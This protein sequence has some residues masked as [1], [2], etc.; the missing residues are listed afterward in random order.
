MH[1]NCGGRGAV[2]AMGNP[3]AGSAA[4]TRIAA[5]SARLLSH[6]AGVGCSERRRSR[7]ESPV[8]CDPLAWELHLAAARGTPMPARPLG[9]QNFQARVMLAEGCSL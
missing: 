9:C 5:N 2:E 3:L 1:Q 8:P 6:Y 7:G 4:L